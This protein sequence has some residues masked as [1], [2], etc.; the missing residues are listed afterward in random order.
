MKKHF[1]LLGFF[2]DKITKKTIGISLSYIYAV[3]VFLDI[4][5]QSIIVL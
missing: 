5:F 4:I 1:L 3:A 2:L